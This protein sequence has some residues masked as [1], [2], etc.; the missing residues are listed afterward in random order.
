M[1]QGGTHARLA[2]LAAN[3]SSIPLLS[4][5]S[6]E[7][8]EQTGRTDEAQATIFSGARYFKGRQL[9]ALSIFELYSNNSG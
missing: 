9:N 8:T 3:H 6:D 1:M 4:L 2:F 7:G 5:A